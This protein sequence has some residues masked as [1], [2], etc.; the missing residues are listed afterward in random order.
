[1]SVAIKNQILTENENLSV[2]IFSSLRV[3]SFLIKANLD[4]QRNF[5][6]SYFLVNIGILI[7]WKS[8]SSQ[9]AKICLYRLEFAFYQDL[10][11]WKIIEI[12]NSAEILYR[13]IFALCR[14]LRLWRKLGIL[15]VKERTLLLHYCWLKF[16]PSPSKFLG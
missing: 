13:Q 11:F 2:Q 7:S 9:K 4:R 1:M 8:K 15:I 6:C 10:R 16:N 14:D 5:V 3:F 12:I